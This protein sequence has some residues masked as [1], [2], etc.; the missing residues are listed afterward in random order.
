METNGTRTGSFWSSARPL[1]CGLAV[2]AGLFRFVPYVLPLHIYNFAPLGALGIF[3]GARL[4]WWQALAIPI[5]IM[6]VTDLLLWK[7]KGY[8][9]FDPFVYGCFLANVALGRM[10]LSRT[11]SPW[12]IGAVSLFA[13]IQFFLVT[14]FGAWVTDIH[15]AT[16][17]YT[18]DWKGLLE[19]Y[20]LG[21]AFFRTEAWPLG[22]FGNAVLGDLF[23][24]A[25]LF[26][27]HAVLTR[28]A[29]PAER[30]KPATGMAVSH[31]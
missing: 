24:S 20:T 30:V 5:L 22:F 25:V 4:K 12:R 8:A 1:A 2:A 14:N 28:T 26:G 21:I 17:L 6:A 7:W 19:C 9:P 16:P 23:F 18:S 31:G 10:L 15:S 13:S 11:E 29:F 27:G 3:G